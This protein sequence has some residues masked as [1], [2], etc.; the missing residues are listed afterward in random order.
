MMLRSVEGTNHTG[1]PTVDGCKGGSAHV[2]LGKLVKLD[3]DLVLRAAL[4]LRFDLL[5]LRC[6]ISTLET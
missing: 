6:F 2:E 5:G 3:V 4:A 1:R